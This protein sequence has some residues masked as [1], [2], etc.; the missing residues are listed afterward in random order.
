[1]PPRAPPTLSTSAPATCGAID[2]DDRVKAEAGADEI[3][4]I[5]AP[6]AVAAIPPN[7]RRFLMRASSVSSPHSAAKLRD[8][9]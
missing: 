5:A 9:G 4:T 1:M 6:A 3:A 8:A 2:G 7:N